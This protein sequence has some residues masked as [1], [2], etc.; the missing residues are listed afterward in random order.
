MEI[1]GQGGTMPRYIAK[2]GTVIDTKTGTPWNSGW[3]QKEAEVIA[4]A[5]NTGDYSK[6]IFRHGCYIAGIKNSR[7]S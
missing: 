5:Y 6:L 4:E 2:N 1:N 3:S 7:K